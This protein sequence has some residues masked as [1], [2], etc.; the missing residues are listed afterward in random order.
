MKQPKTSSLKIDVTETKKIR[1]QMAKKKSIKITINIDVATLEKLRQISEETGVPYQRLLNKLL[2]ES[3][4]KSDDT[5]SR[6]DKLENE[7][8]KLKRKLAA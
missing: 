5:I 7:V 4:N 3:L 8:K 6:L 2:Q 1:E